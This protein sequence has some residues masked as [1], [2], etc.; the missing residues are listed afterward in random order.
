MHKYYQSHVPHTYQS[1]ITS[2]AAFPGPVSHNDDR[3]ISVISVNVSTWCYKA[4][5]L[6]QDQ[7][8]YTSFYLKAVHVQIVNIIPAF[9]ELLSVITVMS[10]MAVAVRCKARVCG[11]SLPGNCGFKSRRGTWMP[12]S[13]ECCLLSGRGLCVGLITRPEESYRVWCV[14]IVIPR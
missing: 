14:V 2:H 9:T 12:I 10:L 6:W 13:R 8:Q 1:V 11:L 5:V 4:L 3:K 7:R